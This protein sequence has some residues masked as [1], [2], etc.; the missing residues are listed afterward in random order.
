MSKLLERAAYLR[1]LAEGMELNPEK[2]THKLL[3]ELIALN[4]EMAAE[5]EAL[6]SRFTDLS[7]FVEVLDNDLAEVEESVENKYAAD[8]DD[9]DGEEEA[10]NTSEAEDVDAPES[11]YINCYCPSCGAPVQVDAYKV[12]LD[13]PVPCPNCGEEL[14]PEAELDEED[15][16][17]DEEAAEEAVK[18]AIAE[19]IEEA[20]EEVNI[21]PDEKEE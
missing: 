8:E 10:E 20:A 7:E 12:N 5:I 6:N 19:A 2:N 17:A 14:F 11:F 18:E 13:E 3:Q 1:G 9:E 15:E 21:F 16:A 4:N